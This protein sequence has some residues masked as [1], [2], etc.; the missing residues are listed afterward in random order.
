MARLRQLAVSGN[1]EIIQY[2]GM[3]QTGSTN[4]LFAKFAWA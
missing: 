1:M 4:T 3:T 2:I